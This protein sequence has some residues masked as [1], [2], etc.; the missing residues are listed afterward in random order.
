MLMGW[1][2]LDKCV[3]GIGF[4]GIG[5]RVWVYQDNGYGTGFIMGIRIKTTRVWVMG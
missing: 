4:A 5:L 3:M 2:Q 1:I